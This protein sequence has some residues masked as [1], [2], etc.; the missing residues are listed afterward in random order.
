[1]FLSATSLSLRLGP[2]PP[3]FRCVLAHARCEYSESVETART[4]TPSF[5]KSARR[6]LKAR[7]SV[8]HTKVTVGRTRVRSVSL[9]GSVTVVAATRG[10]KLKNTETEQRTVEGVEEEDDPFALVLLEFNGLQDGEEVSTPKL[11]E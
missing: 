6:S 8:G 1:M 4:S 5:S 3:S 2:S 7:I 11:E 10:K 9:S